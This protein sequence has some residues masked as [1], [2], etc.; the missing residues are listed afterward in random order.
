MGIHAFLSTLSIFSA[1]HNKKLKKKGEKRMD[2]WM[3]GMDGSLEWMAVGL[4]YITIAS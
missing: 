2:G 1:F 4:I 3:F